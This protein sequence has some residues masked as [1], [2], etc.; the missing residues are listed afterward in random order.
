L[1]FFFTSSSGL[2]CFNLGSCGWWRD[3]DGNFFLLLD[4]LI[5]A[6]EDE[7]LF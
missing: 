2:C 6:I 3:L 5:G 7:L 1:D 4:F